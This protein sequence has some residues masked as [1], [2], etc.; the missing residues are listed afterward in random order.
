MKKVVM[1]GWRKGLV[2]L[3]FQKRM[4][5]WLGGLSDVVGGG[6]LVSSEGEAGRGLRRRG[7]GLTSEALLR[8]LLPRVDIFIWKVVGA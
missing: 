6:G 7:G 5:R 3:T 8:D 2:P 1:G 4:R